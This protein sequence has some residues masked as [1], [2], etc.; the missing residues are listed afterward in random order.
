MEI[1][2][3]LR[4]VRLMRKKNL[5]YFM[6]SYSAAIIQILIYNSLTDQLNHFTVH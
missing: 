5:I 2:V 1:Y 6:S 3:F 4:K